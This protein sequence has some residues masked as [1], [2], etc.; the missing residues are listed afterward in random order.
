MVR[1]ER[2]PVD[3]DAIVA[4]D[5]VEQ[6]KE[7]ERVLL[8]TEDRLAP[9]TAVHYVVPRTGLVASGGACHIGS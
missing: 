9:R 4:I 8:V 5:L 1:H 7:D 2:V 3:F 6:L